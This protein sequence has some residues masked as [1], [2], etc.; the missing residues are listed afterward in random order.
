MTEENKKTV[1]ISKGLGDAF[2]Q[3]IDAC[4]NLIV[5]GIEK[6][7]AMQFRENPF[8]TPF[9]VLMVPIVTYLVT[10][11]NLIASNFKNCSIF[12]KEFCDL[13]ANVSFETSFISWLVMISI[14]FLLVL[15]L[16]N[17]VFNDKF[18]KL[19]EKL[20][21]K[22]GDGEYPKIKRIKELDQYK[23]LLTMNLNG[24]SF[25]KLKTQKSTIES[26]LD[27]YVESIDEGSSPTVAEIT[28]C[29]RNLPDSITYSSL[30]KD[31]VLPDNSFYVGRSRSG[32]IIEDLSKLP[33]MLIAGATGGGKSVF[34]K[35]A[36]LGLLQSSPKMEMYLIDLKCGVEFKD[37][38]GLSNVKIVKSVSEAARVLEAVEQEMYRRYKLFEAS[39]TNNIEGYGKDMNR[40]VVAIDECSLLFDNP[41]SDEAK[42]AKQSVTNLSRLARACGIHLI[43]ATQKVTKET[44]PTHIADNI[45][46]RMI[47]RIGSLQGS[48]QVFGDKSATQIKKHPGRGIWAN[49]DERAN[50]QTPY[51]TEKQISTLCKKINSDETISVKTVDS[52]TSEKGKDDVLTLRSK[53]P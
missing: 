8:L 23:T 21:L 53:Q 28:L 16:F 41:T 13:I 14:S 27:M 7:F 36:L 45:E 20:N 44:I 5:K 30:S 40:L 17:R 35:Q 47:F 51:I 19:V 3:G 37:F 9:L 39:D 43:V 38:K 42:S 2:N 11:A 34:F 4:I 6:L 48:L 29:R 1:S 15:G 33:H 22:S 10:D 24:V 26:I 31:E 52:K 32:S 50:V 12:A 18:E 49:G 25:E 46:G